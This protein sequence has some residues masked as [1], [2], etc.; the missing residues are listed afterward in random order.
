M[1]D[2]ASNAVIDWF[3]SIMDYMSNIVITWFA[4]I[5][6]W[7]YDFGVNLI[8]TIAA[9]I[10]SKINTMINSVSGV[11]TIISDY[12]GFHSP[13]KKWPG[14]D[15]DK[16]M[17]SMVRMMIDG[18]NQN[19][20][21]FE[22]TVNDLAA[23]LG[24]GFSKKKMDEIKGN[25]REFVTDA[26]K[27]FNDMNSQL[28]KSFDKVQDLGKEW[29]DLRKK[30]T[31]ILSDISDAQKDKT[32]SLAGRAV[33]IQ[34]ELADL[35]KERQDKMNSGTYT[36]QEDTDYQAKIEALNKELAFIR[37]KWVSETDIIAARAE[38]DKTEAQHIIDRA[39]A[40]LKDLEQKRAAIAEEIKLKEDQ[41]KKEWQQYQDLKEAKKKFAKEYFDI[42]NTY[43]DLEISKT[44]QL[45]Q[46]ME[47]LAAAKRKAWEGATGTP[48]RAIGWPVIAGRTYTVWENWPEQFVAPLGGGRII[49]TGGATGG[50]MNQTINIT[51][52][53]PVVRDEM[54]IRKIANTV[55][56]VLKKEAINYRLN[57]A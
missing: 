43:L 21:P 53:R 10:D 56:E 3:G 15:A 36:G 22:K 45:I 11:A 34:K 7:A 46:K 39:D 57:V 55:K 50:G 17:P 41:I 8:S 9:G 1:M 28:Q 33:E 14:S 32:S 20:S 42:T 4:D 47:D 38:A 40:N 16:W 48:G 27:A 24:K 18:I 23:V 6:D 2:S 25:I 31:D 29:I 26:N 30:M 5:M 51:I 54:D 37:E 44:E 35:A 19:K 49:P 52:D 13:T 12:L